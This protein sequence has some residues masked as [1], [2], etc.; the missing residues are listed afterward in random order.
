MNDDQLSKEIR[1][2]NQS[3]LM[4]AKTPLAMTWQERGVLLGSQRTPP[5]QGDFET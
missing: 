3:H 1:D 5:T 2:A 4:L